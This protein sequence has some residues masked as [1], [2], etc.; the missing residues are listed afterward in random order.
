MSLEPF[1]YILIPVA[2]WIAAQGGK[3]ALQALKRGDYKQADLLYKSGGMPSSH[4]A[5]VVSLATTIGL[6]EGFQ[7]AQFGL[8]AVLASIVIYDAINVRRAVGEQGDALFALTKDKKELTFFTAKGHTLPQ[9]IAGGT[10]GFLASV[11][12]LQF[13]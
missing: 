9:V 13:L 10:L 11:I 7:S 3:Y 12:M 6:T 2:A 4:S 8:S 5:V 1:Q